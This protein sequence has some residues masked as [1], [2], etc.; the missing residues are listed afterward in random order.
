MKNDEFAEIWKNTRSD[1]DVQSNLDI[2]KILESCSDES[3]PS[4][5]EIAQQTFHAL[6]SLQLDKD[7]LQDYCQRLVEYRLIDSIDQLSCGKYIRWIRCTSYKD[8]GCGIRSGAEDIH[9]YS[10]VR[11]RSPSE[12]E[13][14]DTL[15]NGGMLSDIKFLENGVFLSALAPG[16]RFPRK[17]KYDNYLIFQKMT[18]NEM[19]MFSICDDQASEPT[20]PVEP[21]PPEPRSVV[22]KSST[23]PTKSTNMGH[24]NGWDN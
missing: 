19:L 24:A 2:A 14:N 4:L 8:S 22:D 10:E 11:R 18:E 21:N 20:I 5:K 23:L 12:Y 6:Q 17:I 3:T 15:A 13:K 9:A 7:T 1:P 16:T